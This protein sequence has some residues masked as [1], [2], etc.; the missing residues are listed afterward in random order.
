MPDR[1]ADPFAFTPLDAS[2]AAAEARAEADA[3]AEDAP[4]SDA[5]ASGVTD[6]VF[7]EVVFD[8]TPAEEWAPVQLV[9]PMPEPS[10]DGVPT[11]PAPQGAP[12]LDAPP[13]PEAELGYDERGGFR[14]EAD[15]AS[16]TALAPVA[17]RVPTAPAPQNAAVGPPAPPPPPEAP[18]AQARRAFR[19]RLQM[20]SRHK[21][22]ILSVFLVTLGAFAVYS[23][24]APR[25]YTAYST[26]LI[27]AENQPQGSLG[28]ASAPGSED[29]RVLNQ[30]LVLQQAPEIS[31]STAQTLLGG[32]ASDALTTVQKAADRFGAPVTAESLGEYLR[33]KVVSVEPAGELSDGVQINAVAGDPRE[34]ALI[35]SLYTDEY[36][37][38]SREVNR[39]DVT[40]TRELLEGQLMQREG[41]LTEIEAQL[42]AF[43]TRENAAGLE[44]QT[45]SAVSQ[46]GS[47]ESQLD[48]ARAEISQRQATLAQLEAEAASAQSRLAQSAPTAASG[49]QNAEVQRQITQIETLLNQALARNPDLGGN[50][51]AHP[52]TR[53]MN[54]R[55]QA[56]R[57]EQRRISQEQASGVVN[58]GGLDLT[59]PGANGGAYVAELQRRIADERS[60]L[61]G[62]RARAGSLSGRLGSARGELRE[63]PAQ[64]VELAQLR[65]RR[66][67]AEEALV[68]LQRQLDQTSLEEETELAV[69]QLIRPAEVP[70][71]PSSPNTL[72]N[73]ALGSILG[74]LLGVAAAAVR[75]TTDSRAHTPD[76]LK[77][78]GFAVIGTVPDLTD[79]L[80]RGRQTVNGV[81]VHPGLVT[82]TEAFSPQAEAFRHLHAALASGAGAPQVVVVTSPEAGVGKSVL[83][84][85][86]AAA[87]AQAGRR[88]LLVD[89]DLRTPAVGALLGLGESPALGEGGTDLNVV[90]WSTV[91]PGLF[92]VTARET[93]E[94]P[95]QAWAPEHVGE[96]LGHLRSTFDLILIDAPSAIRTA[97]AALLAPF[98]DAAL[99]VAEAG[100]TDLDAM[101]QVAGELSGAGLH[102]VGAVLNRFEPRKAVGY[103]RTAGARLQPAA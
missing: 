47:L 62:A 32:E 52:D 95:G 91:V 67:I 76:D 89:A 40:E 78:A 81:D 9:E 57:A 103:T 60:A 65:R 41:E 71:K 66:G 37:E 27:N 14:I 17:A 86:L 39:A 12:R 11:H 79:A 26:L 22:L 75:Y 92:A 10:G 70:R 48:N 73:L 56:L 13:A 64:E 53:A 80:R 31:E 35:A 36:L 100:E 7:E 6:A 44:I 51:D 58:S 42:E 59:S 102:R 74:L 18:R 21:W 23:L 3:R 49:A 43:M 61:S 99:L 45:Q 77:A 85:N 30:L 72:L 90:Y 50:P 33:E 68:T 34:A 29:T 93:P 63:K 46:I 96:L 2:R 54:Q 15:H 24:L 101:T 4:T 87:G 38:H 83:A 20:L 1:P 88:V 55:L 84:A 69:A 82:V 19:D 5:T 25:E 98:A 97:D 28:A 94:A 16:S 8:P